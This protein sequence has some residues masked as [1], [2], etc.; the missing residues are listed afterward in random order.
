[1]VP[2][3]YC[4]DNGVLR[5]EQI[6]DRGR[7]LYLCA[8]RGQ[9]VEGYLVVAPYRCTGCLAA[10]PTGQFAELL[11]MKRLVT[12]YFR[13]AYGV[14][15]AL[16]YE[17]GR[18]G[19]GTA[20]AQFP[21]HAH[22]CGL[23]L[24]LDVHKLLGARYP[25][26]R[27]AGLRDLPAVAAGNP[28]VYLDSRGQERVYL[29][30]DDADRAELARLRLKPQIAALAGVPERGHWR[31]HPGDRELQRLLDRFTVYRGRTSR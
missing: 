4:L 12:E 29:P 22:L 5:S 31:D 8:P 11:R 10:L 14:P 17:Q 18:A 7:D 3:V 25:S 30:A 19:G 1:M 27:V 28:Y 9:L 2:C 23:P 20:A 26:R 16:F 13:G 24:D 21:L 15:R 6:V